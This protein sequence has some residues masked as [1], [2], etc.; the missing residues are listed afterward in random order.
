MNLN[1]IS[2]AITLLIAF[3]AA[4]PLSASA[5]NEIKVV[6][7]QVSDYYIPVVKEHLIKGKVTDRNG[8]QIGRASCRERV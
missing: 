5:D 3:S 7:G 6:K 2:T 8:Q 1:P 4:T